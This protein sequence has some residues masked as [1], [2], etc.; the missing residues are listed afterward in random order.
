MLKVGHGKETMP[1][2]LRLDQLQFR[3]SHWVIVD[4]VGKGGRRLTVPVPAWQGACGCL[5]P[6]FGC[7][8]GESVQTGF[9]EWCATRCWR[10]SQRG[11]V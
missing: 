7:E 6:P 3:E 5:A 11:P 1:S 2:D 9:E 10:D 4:L 8:R